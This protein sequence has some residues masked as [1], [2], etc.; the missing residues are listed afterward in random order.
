MTKK[1]IDSV[2]SEKYEDLLK[3]AGD[4]IARKG[5][6]YDPQDVLTDC[7]F[8]C[9][10]KRESIDTEKGC[11]YY[12]KKFI[13]NEITWFNSFTNK[14]QKAGG[15][16]FEKLENCLSSIEKEEDLQLNWSLLSSMSADIVLKNG[17][18]KEILRLY[19]EGKTTCRE[20]G[21]ALGASE[22]TGMRRLAGMKKE[23]KNAAETLLNTNK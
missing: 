23:V 13:K 12:A 21:D 9:L 14:Q 5:K 18:Y 16:E 1:Q 3:V 17:K 19:L 11:F 22:Q 8:K 15:V 4:F 6:T 10:E 2:F 20:I 7:Y